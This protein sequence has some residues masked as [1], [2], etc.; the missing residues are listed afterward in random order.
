M[1]APLTLTLDGK[2]LAHQEIEI[3]AH[4]RRVLIFP[5]D[6]ARTDGCV[7]RLE[8]NDDLPRTIKPTWLL[9]IA[10]RCACF[11]SVREILI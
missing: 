11:M 5:Y 7:A 1:R 6:G 2:T 8:I 9:P 10:P 3:G 4:D